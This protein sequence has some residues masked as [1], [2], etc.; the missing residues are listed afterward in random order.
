MTID[1]ETGT[2]PKPRDSSSRTLTASIEKIFLRDL[3]AL[4]MQVE[5]YEKEEDLWKT[6][7]GV[8][9]PAGNLAL[10][11]CGNLQHFVG[12]QLGGTGYVR[13]RVGEFSGRGLTRGD[14]AAEIARTIE[15][16]SS[17]LAG[18][19]D[20]DLE[21]TIPLKLADIELGVGRFL[22]HLISHFGYH[23]GQVDYHRR[24]LTGKGALAGML[25]IPD[26]GPGG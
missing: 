3:R 12:A 24:I 1:R 18:L 4:S 19:D 8:E 5:A 22:L 2:R 25:A 6:V 20:R 13:N 23:L 17:S 11:L 16:V 10:H 9:N 26:L 21:Q 7:P 15:A 14:I